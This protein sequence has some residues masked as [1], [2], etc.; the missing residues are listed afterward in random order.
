MEKGLGE[1]GV[2]PENHRGSRLA[3][4]EAEQVLGI[5][6][7][8]ACAKLL[9]R[10]P[11]N[12][13][14]K[15][16][17]KH[18]HTFK[19]EIAIIGINPYVDVPEEVLSGIFLKAGKDKGPVPVR[20]SINEVPYTQTL[21]RYAGEWRLYINTKMLKDSPK[22]IGEVI[23]ITIDFDPADRMLP[24]HPKLQDALGKDVGAQ[25][26]FE[27][28]APSLQNE[29]NRY[30]VNLKSEAKVDENVQRAIHFLNGRGKFVG[31]EKLSK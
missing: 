2:R 15:C 22:R 20:G 14:Q 10:S 18:M 28:L 12:E 6:A 3:S 4:V 5:S 31:R 8:V 30:I 27:S 21:V 25:K 16:K 29:I 9:R 11:T 1:A 13:S 19:A 26:V 23:T 17:I 7:S 24:I